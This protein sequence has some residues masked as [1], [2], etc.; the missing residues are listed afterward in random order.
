MLFT[1]VDRS[2]S[3]KLIRP[4]IILK[5]YGI[6][7][8]DLFNNTVG[9]LLVK[10]ASGILGNLQLHDYWFNT[11]VPTLYRLTKGDPITVP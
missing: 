5:H 7:L 6:E 1:F 8:M 4:N 3:E 2:K 9:D 11:I 10:Q